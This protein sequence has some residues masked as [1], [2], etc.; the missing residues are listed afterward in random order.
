M[1]K[2]TDLQRTLIDIYAK[3]ETDGALCRGSDITAPATITHIVNAVQHRARF[4]ASHDTAREAVQ[5]LFVS[6]GYAAK[7]FNQ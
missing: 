6:R 5:F 1:R 3:E 7:G 2:L 4:F